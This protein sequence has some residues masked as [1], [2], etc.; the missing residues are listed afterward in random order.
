MRDFAAFCSSLARR[1][2]VAGNLA[3]FVLML[4][5]ASFAMPRAARASVV[6]PIHSASTPNTEY[7]G[8][9]FFGG[10]VY[11]VEASTGADTP[12]LLASGSGVLFGV[13]CS[14]GSSGDF[15]MVFDSA[16]AS[17]V[18]IATTGKA[19]SPAVLSSA[20]GVTTCTGQAVCG[21][22]TPPGGSVRFSNGLVA[23]KHG[24]GG[25]NDN[26]QVYALT[27]AEISAASTH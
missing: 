18:T 8:L 11:R 21:Q 4:V 27:D 10:S 6:P 22:W 25:A 16:S 14:S 15:G 26:C 7:R 9:T 3:V 17:G 5:L 19:L 23:I 20:N 24:S 13:S 1:A 2:Y 12:V